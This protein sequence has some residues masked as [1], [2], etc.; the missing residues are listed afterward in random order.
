M[1]EGT[2]ACLAWGRS[3][4]AGRG[5]GVRS[6]AAFAS[7]LPSPEPLLGW[8]PVPEAPPV[9]HSAQAMSQMGP[10]AKATPAVWLS[11]QPGRG[12]SLRRG[13]RW[14][15]VPPQRCGRQ[16]AW[17]PAPRRAGAGP[18]ILGGCAG[19]ASPH[20]ASAPAP[21]RGQGP[22]APSTVDTLTSLLFT[23]HTWSPSPWGRPRYSFYPMCET[24]LRGVRLRIWAEADLG[25]VG[26]QSSR[27]SRPL[28]LPRG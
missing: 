21:G 18:G 8:P 25:A 11:A 7:G 3:P 9:P 5:L 6:L 19:P 14:P 28:M 26:C 15:Q 2:G 4:A 17:A 10:P 16:Q 20:P 22:G 23:A 24:C 27:G 1:T 13:D 12:V